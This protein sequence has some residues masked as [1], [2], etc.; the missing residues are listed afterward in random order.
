VIA[1]DPRPMSKPSRNL[2]RAVS[3]LD[4]LIA[5]TEAARMGTCSDYT[6]PERRKWRAKRK[7]EPQGGRLARIAFGVC[8]GAVLIAFAAMCIRPDVVRAVLVGMVP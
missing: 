4:A 2:Q 6:G 8:G 1:L 7:A 3:D 5:R